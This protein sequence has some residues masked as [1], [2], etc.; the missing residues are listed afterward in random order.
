MA[1]SLGEA[2]KALYRKRD[3]LL[4]Q[5]RV[6]LE[7]DG[8]RDRDARDLLETLDWDA[9]LTAEAPARGSHV[10]E[11]WSRPSATDGQ[12]RQEGEP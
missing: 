8:I 11:A 10:D 6:E 12:T 3:A 4:K 7:A 1:K 9:A 2:Q 5:L